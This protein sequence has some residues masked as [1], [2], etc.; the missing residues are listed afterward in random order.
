MLA[1]AGGG[2]DIIEASKQIESIPGGMELLTSYAAEELMKAQGIP[3]KKAKKIRLY[4]MGG[5]ASANPYSKGSKEYKDWDRK[6]VQPGGNGDIPGLAKGGSTKAAAEKTRRAGRGDDSVMLHMTPEEAEVIEA[7][8]G[9]PDINPNTGIGEYGFLSKVWKKV[10]KGVKKVFK[11]KVFR[12]V[13]PI[14]L[15]IFAPGIGT[16][17]G[18]K[19]GLSGT[20]ASIAGNA[21]VQGGLGAA[22]GGKEGA[23]RGA[24][25]GGLGSAAGAYGKAAGEALG[26]SG[27]TADVVGSAV[28]RGGGEQLTGGDFTSGAITGGLG[29]ATRGMQDE[30]GRDVRGSLGLQRDVPEDQIFAG[31]EVSAP[32]GD[33]LEGGAAPAMSP[34]SDRPATPEELLEGDVAP[35]ATG[36]VERTATPVTSPVEAAEPSLTL[37]QLAQKYAVPAGVAALGAL[38]AAR[39]APEEGPPEWYGRQG[40]SNFNEDLPVYAMN[41]EFQGLPNESDYFTYGQAGAP[42]SGQHL[43]LDPRPFGGGPQP[44]QPPAQGLGAIVQAL[45]NQ[46]RGREEEESFGRTRTG[47]TEFVAQG[48]YMPSDG[49]YWMQNEDVAHA[50]PMVN[51]EGGHQ[52]SGPGTGR[53][54][55][56]PAM[57]SDGE[58]VIDAETVALLG[59]GSGNAGARRLDE[60]RKEIRKHKAGKLKKGEFTH[61]AKKPTNYMRNVR[62][63]KRT[64][65]YEHGG[66]VAGPSPVPPTR[67]AGGNI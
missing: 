63:L 11:S 67:A 30:L 66:N 64:A 50:A 29:A 41:R 15:S 6:Y 36:R 26:L 13:A 56:I 40:D 44:A 3:K 59:D 55:D 61:K 8:W 58:Y 47:S 34:T 2:K 7:M 21:L 46:A 27:K 33:P 38:S 37:P 53:S 20:A 51:R 19:L 12:I 9:A 49:D 42:Q 48:G 31:R 24:V 45:Q 23:I 52:V 43:F 10:K 32:A 18:L 16:A 39:G 35:D 25:S 54:D 62:K 4:Q 57:L 1:E 22:T 65:K 60:M 14:A 5:Y 17:I 28:I